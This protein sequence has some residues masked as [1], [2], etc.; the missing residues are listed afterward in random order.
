MMVKTVTS[1]HKTLLPSTDLPKGREGTMT[2]PPP[3]GGPELPCPYH[4]QVWGQTGA[5]FALGVAPELLSWL[6]RDK[7]AI[8]TAASPRALKA[9]SFGEL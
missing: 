5:G 8:T 9:A 4:I 6:V 7:S 2:A 3:Q 1:E